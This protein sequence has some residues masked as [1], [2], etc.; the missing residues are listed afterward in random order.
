MNARTC[1]QCGVQFS[2][3]HPRKV[4]CDR[5]CLSR[6]HGER[7]SRDRRLTEADHTRRAAR[8]IRRLGGSYATTCLECQSEFEY[9]V[10]QGRRPQLC[11][12]TCKG[13]RRRR[14]ELRE[15]YGI[16]LEHYESLWESQ[17]GVCAICSGNL[18][19]G[20]DKYAA[21]DHD[22]QTGQVRGLL[23][24]RCNLALGQF[25]D[26]PKLLTLALQYVT[27]TPL[28]PMNDNRKAG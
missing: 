1:R 25:N 18:L 22:H 24:H 28:R 10:A 5:R 16:E 7:R 21:V 11:S 4:F 13:R 26:D 8:G 12:A 23:C 15:K 2:A 6:W 14:L 17:T 27:A 3:S 20:S 19:R 9:V